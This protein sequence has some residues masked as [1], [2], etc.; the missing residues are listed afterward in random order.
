M[1]IKIAINGTGRI[2][3][4]AIR[5]ASQRKDVEIVAINSTAELETLLHLIR[6]DSVH[7]HFEAK[8]NANR[9]LNIGHSKNILVLSERDINKLDFS[10][11][12]AEIIIECTGKFNSL[13]A[14]SAHLKNSVKKVI[15]SA[16]A[17][18]APTFVYGVNHTNYHNES[19]ISNAS[20]TTNATAPLLKILDEAFKVENALLTTIHSYT[21]DQNLL[22]T[23][24]KDIR[25]A[26]AASLNLIP[27]S[28]GVSKAISLVLPHLGSKVTGLAIRVPTP[29]VSLVDL[30]L[31]FKK[32]VS[33]AS[34][35]HAL[36]DASK[37]A[38]K[39]IVSVD[40]ER[41]VSSD[42]I[43]S[44]FSAIVIDDQIMTIGEKNA[45]VLAWYDNE[46][47]YSERL[48]DMAQYIAQN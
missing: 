16:P 19:V 46:M 5:V 35:H 20:C 33:K 38:F 27:T 45:K 32:V 47:G 42:F 10:V 2:G 18:N 13:E 7:G 48:I 24:H 14:S 29:N 43:S 11:A 23:K 15:I 1:P 3:L 40:E 37:H 17:Q 21:N 41:L 8:L 9:T 26:R 25:R 44:P 34:V 4:C 30:S 31:N 6:H 36:K 12:N 22:D 28:T 39:G